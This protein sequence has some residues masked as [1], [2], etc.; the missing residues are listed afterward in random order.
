MSLF[1]TPKSCIELHFIITVPTSVINSSLNT[2]IWY[3]SAL[4]VYFRCASPEA[5][6]KF[7]RNVLRFIKSAVEALMKYALLLRFCNTPCPLYPFHCASSEALYKR[8]RSTRFNRA[9]TALA[10]KYALQL[11]FT[12]HLNIWTALQVRFS[13]CISR[14]PVLRFLRSAY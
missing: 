1:P 8:C 14:G 6:L 10:R 7:C 9:S 5:R 3:H 11:R 4:Q 13:P 2:A 12:A